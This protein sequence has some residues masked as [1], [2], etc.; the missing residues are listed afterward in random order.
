M[1]GDHLKET[2][3]SLE[4][5]QEGLGSRSSSRFLSIEEQEKKGMDPIRIFKLLCGFL[6]FNKG[7]AGTTLGDE[8]NVR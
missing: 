8:K 3:V 1:P 4:S 2:D 7:I 6:Q 5:G